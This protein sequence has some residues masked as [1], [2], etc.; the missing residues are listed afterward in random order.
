M[1]AASSTVAASNTKSAPAGRRTRWYQFSLK[2]LTIFMVVCSLLMGA[3]AWRLQRARKQAEAAEA[4]RAM[5][6]TVKYDYQWKAID[7]GTKE[8]SESPFPSLLVHELGQDFFHEVHIVYNED[9]APSNE[10][11]TLFWDCVVRFPKLRCLTVFNE[12][13]DHEGFARLRDFQEMELVGIM[14]SRVTDDDLRVIGAMTKLKTLELYGANHAIGDEGVAALDDLSELQSFILRNSQITDAA[15]QHL[16][17]HPK[18]TKLQLG[19][20]PLT[21]KSSPWLGKLTQLQR[22]DIYDTDIGDAGIGELKNLTKLQFLIA[23]GT[24]ITDEGLGQLAEIPGLLLLDVKRTKVTPEGVAR[25]K[26][27]L[28]ACT[29]YP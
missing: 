29:V 19:S 17:K 10:E 14:S 12:W 25:F 27:R 8:P 28:P 1:A 7:Q 3:F 11:R 9:Y 4:I 2:T 18:L 16:V 23:Y 20:N 15:A 5:Q 6:G 22:L 26:A 13:M 24:Q 21:D